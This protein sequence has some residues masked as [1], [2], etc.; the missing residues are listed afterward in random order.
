MIISYGSGIHWR[1]RKEI[2]FWFRWDLL[3]SECRLEGKA[4]ISTGREPTNFVSTMLVEHEQKERIPIC[5]LEDSYTDAV[6]HYMVY[7]PIDIPTMNAIMGGTAD[8]DAVAILA[9]GFAILPDEP[10]NG[11]EG[12]DWS[13]LTIMFQIKDENAS[14]EFIPPQSVATLYN[15]I[16]RTATK[17]QARFASS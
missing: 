3:S 1:H 6:G 10:D 12:F 15:L 2:F 17:I 11:E 9:S 13:I 4:Y 14:P 8:P 16:R 5:Y 7:A